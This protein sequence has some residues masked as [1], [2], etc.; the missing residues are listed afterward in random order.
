VLSAFRQRGFPLLYAGL[1]TSMVG[2]SLMLI[3]LA[4]WVKD[5]TGSSGAAGAT[6]FWLA[7]PAPWRPCSGSSS[8]GSSAAPS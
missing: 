8:T 2:D 4:V 7:L 5:L 3:V 1:L 6:F